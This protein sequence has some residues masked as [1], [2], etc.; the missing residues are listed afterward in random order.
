MSKN[1]ARYITTLVAIILLL[2][3]G[4][5][6]LAVSWNGVLRDS[7][8]PI[9]M[10][11]L[12]VIISS[13]GIYLFT[14]AIKKTHLQWIHEESRNKQ[15]ESRE[16]KTPAT[17]RTTKIDK[18]L[19]ITSTAR[20]LVRR[21]PENEP[22]SESGKV[23]LKNLAK[24]LEMMSG[25]VYTRQED[26]FQLAAS[27]ALASPTE[28]YTF[29]EGE[30]LSGQ[31]AANQEIMILTS[32]PEGHLEVYSGLGKSAPAYL[33]IVPLVHQNRTIAL[34]ECSGYRFDPHDIETMFRIFARDLMI[35]L[36]PFIK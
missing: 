11:F 5:G 14:H 28:P 1:K 7:P 9:L 33:A 17:A 30:G 21:I 34:I 16:I 35:K 22:L 24:E 3:S 18:R 27:F 23:L 29:R 12:W 36:S 20:K 13:S 2:I 32:L 4:F 6:L 26:V 15:A 19:D 8:S 25:V 31:A 10:I